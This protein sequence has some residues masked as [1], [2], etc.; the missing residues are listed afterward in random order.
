MA[1]YGENE[2]FTHTQEEVAEREAQEALVVENF[3]GM[4]TELVTAYL[5]NMSDEELDAALRETF[6]ELVRTQYAEAAMAEIAAICETP[7]AMEL[8]GLSAQILSRLPDAMSRIGFVAS[9]YAERTAMPIETI[10]AY[11]M[12]LDGTAFDAVLSELVFIS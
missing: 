11:L 7:S 1:E 2:Y 8:E 6:S 5:Q 12:S 3:S 10:S 4:D 9:V